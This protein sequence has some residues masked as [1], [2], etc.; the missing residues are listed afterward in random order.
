MEAPSTIAFC[1]ISNIPFALTDPDIS[2][3]APTNML[4]PDIKS[5]SIIVSAPIVMSFK[6]FNLPRARQLLPIFNEP[7][8]IRDLFMVVPEGISK[9]P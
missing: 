6:A 3:R 7:L 9:S 8:T 1:S 2:E 5:P 4:P